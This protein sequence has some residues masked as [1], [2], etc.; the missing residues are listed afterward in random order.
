MKIISWNISYFNDYSSKFEFLKSL[1]TD[2][3]MIIVLQEVTQKV[4]EQLVIDFNENFNIEYSLNYRKASKFDT[5]ARKLGI[6]ILVS[7]D[8]KINNVQVLERTLFPERTLFME[9]VKGNQLFKIMGLHSITGCDYS[10]AKSIQFYSFAETI[11]LYKPDIVAIDANEP[12]VDH[13]NVKEM[14]FFDNKDKGKGAKMFFTTMIENKLEDAFA[15]HYDKNQYCG[16]CLATSHIINKRFNKRYDF[17]FINGEK[18]KFQKTEYNL[19]DAL[20]SG[21]DHALVMV[22]V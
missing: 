14:I 15:L 5:N 4:Y 12:Q 6:A 18:F 19:D 21:S 2:P 9:V 8:F 3:S 11:D 1:V 13:Y 20:K 7:K 22:T 16:E 17:I 10:K